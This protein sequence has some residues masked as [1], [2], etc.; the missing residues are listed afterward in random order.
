MGIKTTKENI[1]DEIAKKY[2]LPNKQV[3][4]AI[5]YQFRFVKT[6]M[7]NL[8]TVR[9]PFFGVFKPSLKQKQKIDKNNEK[10]VKKEN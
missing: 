4:D 10:H 8:N 5:K 1:I 2:K 6:Q 3:E 7:E 9:L